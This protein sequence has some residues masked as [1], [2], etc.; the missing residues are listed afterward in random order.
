MGLPSKSREVG[1]LAEV[2]RVAKVR[3]S[4]C[5]QSVHE[6]WASKDRHEGDNEGHQEHDH[7]GPYSSSNGDPSIIDEG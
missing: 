1:T 3:G 5:V 7:K 4:G 2:D 6:R